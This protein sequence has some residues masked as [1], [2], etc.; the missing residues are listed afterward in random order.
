MI[1]IVYAKIHGGIEHF[2]KFCRF[3]MFSDIS[4]GAKN[5]IPYTNLYGFKRLANYNL[6][7]DEIILFSIVSIS[8][9]NI[10][11]KLLKHIERLLI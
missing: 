5:D 8:L 7:C 10:T 1:E 9:N 3:A 2:L 6:P 4:L 11:R